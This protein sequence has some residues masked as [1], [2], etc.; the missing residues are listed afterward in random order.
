MLCKCEYVHHRDRCMVP[1]VC[2]YT[3]IWVFVYIIVCAST[4][5]AHVW[6]WGMCV[7]VR[8]CANV[9][10][11][12]FRLGWGQVS[13]YFHVTHGFFYVQVSAAQLQ[14]SVLFFA[15]VILPAFMGE[16]LLNVGNAIKRNWFQW[17]VPLP[18]R[19]IATAF[20]L[21]ITPWWNLVNFMVCYY[22]SRVDWERQ[23]LLAPCPKFP[24]CDGSES[25][26]LAVVG[27][28]VNPEAKWL[29]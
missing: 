3:R 11:W 29:L 6:T 20:M 8:V 2:F 26:K 17:N 7:W 22:N 28:K 27:H 14:M 5:R 18:C 12:P 10:M 21:R 4:A 23:L 25:R 19:H 16:K 15:H 13:F 24:G 1:A 9:H